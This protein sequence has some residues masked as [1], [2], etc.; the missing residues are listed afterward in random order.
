MEPDNYTV[1][2]FYETLELRLIGNRRNVN[3][4]IVTI[5]FIIAINLYCRCYKFADLSKKSLILRKY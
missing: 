4:G 2:I 1:L 3:D 5:S